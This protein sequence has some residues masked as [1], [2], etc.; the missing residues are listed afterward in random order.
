MSGFHDVDH[1]LF[2]YCTPER[3]L[4]EGPG[5]AASEPEQLT[6]PGDPTDWGD[7]DVF[8]AVMFLVDS[9]LGEFAIDNPETPA[10]DLLT[11]GFLGFCRYPDD[12]NRNGL[13][14][15]EAHFVRSM[16]R[17]YLSDRYLAREAIR[18]AMIFKAWAAGISNLFTDHGQDWPTSETAEVQT[19]MT[20]QEIFD[21]ESDV[22][23]HQKLIEYM[24][25]AHRHRA[26]VEREAGPD[27]ARMADSQRR[28]A[29]KGGMHP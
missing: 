11:H 18:M 17:P 10:V 8:R 29:E 25:A 24:T 22:E 15:F 9:S 4:D 27:Y 20:L 28:A 13:A 23:R 16:S 21:L 6:L 14:L 7:D 2:P 26:Y 3:R 19:G 12:D 1:R 5:P